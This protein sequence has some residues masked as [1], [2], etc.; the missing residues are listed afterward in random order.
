MKKIAILTLLLAALALPGAADAASVEIAVGAWYVNPDGDISYKPGPAGDIDLKS[1]VAYD[2]QWEPMFRLKTRL[3]LLPNIY[4]QATPLAF[5]ANNHG[6][7]FEFA[8]G[9]AVFFGNDTIDS[10]FFLN[11]YDADLFFRVPLIESGD[12]GLVNI[13]LGAGAR[14]VVLRTDFDDLDIDG[15]D[16][17]D[18]NALDDSRSETVVYPMG[19]AGLDINPSKYV[20]LVGEAWGYSYHSDTLYT[21]VGRL[22]ISPLG[23]LFLSGGYRYDNY[24]FDRKDLDLDATFSGPFAELGLEF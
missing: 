23:P 5:D 14:W 1:H 4:L 18:F 7:A 12:R 2:D 6:D 16:I 20:S 15:G 19:Y 13:E 17:A 22:K 11:I 3:P 8:L 21:L 24:D 9:D 10:E